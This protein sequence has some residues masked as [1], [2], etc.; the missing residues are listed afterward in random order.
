LWGLAYEPCD[1]HPRS[2]ELEIEVEEFGV[3][4]N[5]LTE[6]FTEAFM[7]FGSAVDHDVLPLVLTGEAHGGIPVPP[8]MKVPPEFPGSVVVS[9]KGSVVLRA[10]ARE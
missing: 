8:P 7:V 10:F 1:G 2:I 5:H 9:M 4:A 6:S 3:F